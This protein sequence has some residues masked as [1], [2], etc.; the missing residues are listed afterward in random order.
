MIDLLL[1]VS[2]LRL[3]QYINCNP[4]MYHKKLLAKLRICGIQEN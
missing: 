1:L 4:S 2:T 3:T